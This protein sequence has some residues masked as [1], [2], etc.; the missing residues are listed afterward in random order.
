MDKFKKLFLFFKEKINSENKIYENSIIEL[1]NS[2]ATID[3]INYKNKL[4]KLVE[5]L[6][7]LKININI[8]IN[9]DIVV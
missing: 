9:N 6:N 3:Y 8:N 4:K 7:L 1:I 5:T 2:D